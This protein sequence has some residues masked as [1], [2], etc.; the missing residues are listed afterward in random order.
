MASLNN[1]TPYPAAMAAIPNGINA[2]PSIPIATEPAMIYGAI[3]LKAAATNVNM[4]GVE[5]KLDTL[6][7][8]LTGGAVRVY[9]DGKDVSS[10]MSGIGR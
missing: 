2:N 10:A 4:G 9:L 3:K 7:N 5:A 6:T 8:L 1:F